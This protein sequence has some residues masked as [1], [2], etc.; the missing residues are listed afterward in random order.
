MTVGERVLRLAEGLLQGG[1][2]RHRRVLTEWNPVRLDR[3]LLLVRR[4][5]AVCRR[6]DAGVILER[7]GRLFPTASGPR[8]REQHADAGVAQSGTPSDSIAPCSSL[9]G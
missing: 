6:W 3:A 9:G 5:D 1:K 8:A 2:N 4:A 7:G